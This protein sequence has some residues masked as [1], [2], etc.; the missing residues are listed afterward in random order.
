M[1]QAFLANGAHQPRSSSDMWMFGHFILD[2]LQA[3]KPLAHEQLTTSQAWQ[4]ALLLPAAD[5]RDVPALQAHLEYLRS[6]IGPQ[7][8]YASQVTFL[9]APISIT[10]PLLCF[11][12][13]SCLPII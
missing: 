10:T 3:H 2:L 13:L 8:T 4:E 11:S 1:A 5:P 7:D 12:C 6:L 9:I